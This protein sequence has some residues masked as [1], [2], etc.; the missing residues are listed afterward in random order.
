MKKLKQEE[1]N[2]FKEPTTGIVHLRIPIF[3]GGEYTLCGDAYDRP[4]TE[5]GE[6]AMI[7]SNEVCNCKKCIEIADSL[8]PMLKTEMRRIKRKGAT[9]G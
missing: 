2:C 6:E 3:C 9:N 8:F 1:S 7:D 4:S 5:D